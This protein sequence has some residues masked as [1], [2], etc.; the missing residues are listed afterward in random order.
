MIRTDR[1]SIHGTFLTVNPDSSGE[2][3]AGGPPRDRR[4]AGPFSGAGDVTVGFNASGP[5]TT[6]GH[7]G[8]AGTDNNSANDTALI[9]IGVK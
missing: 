4:A 7:V 1:S 3:T 8:F 6:T 5:M 9:T 2:V